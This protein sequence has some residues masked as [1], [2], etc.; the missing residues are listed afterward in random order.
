MDYL[1]ETTIIPINVYGDTIE[2]L[3]FGSYFAHQLVILKNTK[4]KDVTTYTITDNSLENTGIPYPIVHL[5][6]IEPGEYELYTENTEKTERTYGFNVIVTGATKLDLVARAIKTA[7][8]DSEDMQDFV[9]YLK[10]D[11]DILSSFFRQYKKTT[12]TDMKRK[13]ADTIQTLLDIRNRRIASY[14]LTVTK[15]VLDPENKTFKMDLFSNKVIRYDIIDNRMDIYTKPLYVAEHKLQENT[16]HLYLYFEIKKSNDM[17]INCT[18]SFRPTREIEAARKKETQV[19]TETYTRAIERTVSY[20]VDTFE[21]SDTELTYLSIIDKLQSSVP[22]MHSPT[23]S[24]EHGMITVT[25]FEDDLPFLSYA[26]PILYL[27]IT[28]PEY[29]IDPGDRRKISMSANIFTIYNESVGLGA[30]LYLYWIEDDKGT[31]ISDIKTFDL[32][33]YQESVISLIYDEEKNNTLNEKLR[34]LDI[35]RYGEH[36]KPYILSAAQEYFSTAEDTLRVLEEDPYSDA[37][38]AA[39][40]MLVHNCTIGHIYDFAPFAFAV[41]QDHAIYGRY[42]QTF[43]DKPIYYKYTINTVDLPIGTDTLYKIE[44]YSLQDGWSVEY[45][46]GSEKT[47]I[48][49]RFENVDYA[50][51]S[52]IKLSDMSVS[53]FLMFDFSKKGF[54][55]DVSKFMIKNVEVDF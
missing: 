29:S 42:R 9:S 18:Y 14:N 51:L 54:R 7:D 17:P 2:A 25:P 40:N 49:Y 43:F 26:Y 52:A 50:F 39:K 45:I 34:K 5:T 22:L 4:T 33:S 35:Y 20:P 8:T 31:V 1:H 15:F 11:S 27:V 6:K 30:E 24:Y 16:N 12:D 36:L 48:A 3:F 41:M 21:F 46:Q 53:G 28:E 37:S 44:K 55:A 10:E 23:L 38:S 19:R 32:S 47:A 13:F